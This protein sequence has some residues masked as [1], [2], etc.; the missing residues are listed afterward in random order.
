MLLGVYLAKGDE[1]VLKTQR[2]YSTLESRRS[3]RNEKREKQGSVKNSGRENNGEKKKI[4]YE[5]TEMFSVLQSV[6]ANGR[7]QK[8]W[9]M[10]LEALTDFFS[11]NRYHGKVL[12]VL[13]NSRA[14]YQPQ[15]LLRLYFVHIL[16]CCF[17]GTLS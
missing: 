17:I 1:L 7:E 16:F 13:V 15:K 5:R 8:K 9:F 14:K 10:K 6:T 12:S 4:G 3:K 2:N 11:F